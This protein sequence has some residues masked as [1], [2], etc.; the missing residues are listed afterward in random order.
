MN[1][2]SLEDWYLLNQMVLQV[3]SHLASMK[4]IKKAYQKLAVKWHPDKNQDK[5]RFAQKRFVEISQA[6]EVLSD[7]KKKKKYA[8]V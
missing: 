1:T 8:I 4:L 6:Y 2:Q 5:K 3:V 7:P